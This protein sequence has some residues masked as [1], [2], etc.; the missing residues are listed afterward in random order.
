MTAK[1]EAI[2]SPAATTR[3]EQT[4]QPQMG[5]EHPATLSRRFSLV[6]LL[7]IASATALFLLPN[8]HTPFLGDDA[9][10][11]NFKGIMG[12]ER[13]S[14]L[15]WFVKYN[16]TVLMAGRFFPG[17][18]VIQIAKFSLSQ[19]P[20]V[21]KGLNTAAI[22]LNIVTFY[23]V[24][25]QFA[26]RR[27]ALLA[28]L[29]VVTTLQVRVFYES[30]SEITVENQAVWELLLITTLFAFRFA[31][32]PT[33]VN[34]AYLSALYIVTNL[35]YEISFLFIGVYSAI[36]WLQAGAAALKR[37][38]VPLTLIFAA[39]VGINIF[40]R[41][42]IP[43]AGTSEY[44]I[45]PSP[46]NYLVT[47]WN[48]TASAFPLT[49]FL[50][51]PNGIF[52]NRVAVLFGIAHLG[53][54]VGFAAFAIAL[55]VL[56]YRRPSDSIIANVERVDWRTGA[57]LT[58]AIVVVPALLTCLSQRW[59]QE[60][61]FGLPYQPAY[62]SGFGFALLLALLIERLVR[63]Q[64]RSALKAAL[65]ASIV[66]GAAVFIT[67]QA[68]ADVYPHW[69]KDWKYPYWAFVHSAER[70]GMGSMPEHSIV[71][72]ETNYAL[73]TPDSQYQ[74]F[75]YTNRRYLIEIPGPKLDTKALCAV[76][77]R[78]GS[79]AAAVPNLFFYSLRSIDPNF[80]RSE[81][82]PVRQ[83]DT[84]QLATNHIAVRGGSAL[85]YDE[86]PAIA[87]G[88]QPDPSSDAI[89][90][91][92][93]VDRD[94]YRLYLATPKCGTLDQS[95]VEGHAVS[96]GF[97]RG[98]YPEEIIGGKAF[99]WS[100]ARALLELVNNTDMAQDAAGVVSFETYVPGTHRLTVKIGAHA[101]SLPLH[102]GATPFAFSAHLPPGKSEL[103]GIHADA[104]RVP[105]GADPRDL[106]VR[107]F[108]Y[109][110]HSTAGACPRLPGKSPAG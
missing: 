11:A 81:L 3:S 27:F 85:V 100:S 37:A 33:N 97:G 41:L 107:V 99:H 35:T 4:L 72:Y 53:V 98:F 23:L 14:A 61:R 5:A 47:L 89:A 31:K 95:S 102:L 78:N 91:S 2:A 80:A 7:L 54:V 68:N 44:A 62:I 110:V 43:I 21:I 92:K 42:T 93:L 101:V 69:F 103:I 10:N 46:I 83:F 74:F 24:V 67:Y 59:Q 48:Q 52:A 8:L 36:I 77:I 90:W 109:D 108:D 60:V 29:L 64:R 82:L 40:I 12:Y 45:K 22:V 39:F 19:S 1:Y 70:G 94:G 87:A 88:T 58:G 66:I 16:H 86:T 55:M 15:D 104:P 51:N 75:M 73:H 26:D 34:L 56:M 71:L 76:P 28:A 25:R 38:L 50:A 63:T 6:V 17:M 32:R 65:G 18:T 13:W 79:C 105:S 9:F 96:F 49:Y 84:S 20:E 57:M 106:R 30:I